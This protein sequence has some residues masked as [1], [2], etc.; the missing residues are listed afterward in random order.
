[1]RLLATTCALAL[2]AS[3]AQAEFTLTI[4]HTNDFHD[5]F[6]PI[7]AFA[8]TCTDEQRAA[9][10]CFGGIARLATALAEARARAGE[11]VI[12]LDA[13]DQFSGSLIFT[14]YGGAVAAE[15]MS[16]LG[17]DAMVPGNHEFNR[18]PQG[19]AEF[20]DGV[21]FPV[22]AA[23]LDASRE[24]L[25]AGR[26]AP[27]AV[28]E[29]AGARIGIVGVT[30]VETPVIS[31]PGPNLVF[32]P[33]A[34]VQHEIDRLTA[35]GVTKIVLLSHVGLAE[36]L[37][38]AAALTGVD[39]I[40]GGHSHSLL[41][42]LAEDAQGP[43]PI[44]VG[45]V[46][47]V[48]AGAFGKHLGELAVTFDAD[49]RVISAA[50]EPILLDAAVAEDA[51]T[52]AR[53]FELLGPLDELRNRVVA[54]AAAAIDGT[55]ELCRRAEC[56]MGNL[57]ADAILARAAG[58]GA[59]IALQN[60]GGL[61]ASIDS[62]P[63]TKGEVLTVLPFQNTLSTF[64]ATGQDLLDALENGVSQMEEG[65]GRFPQVAGLRFTVDPS[66]PVGARVSAVEVRQGDGWAPIDPAATYIVASNN[67]VRR[68]GD[69]YAMFADAAKAYDFGPDLAEVV[70][71]Y[72]AAN[73]PYAP[74]TD[75]R[76]TVLGVP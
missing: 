12:L 35:A 32:R 17:Y 16:A 54:E 58:Q 26:I 53:L 1:M 45:A 7:N 47:V 20:L 51:A 52:A 14:Q 74:Y 69:G 62:G 66:R 37:A 49:G 18:G 57:V 73:A 46:A 38:L 72:L 31:S 71:D 43:Y 19:L 42:N 63:I 11:N 44:M 36:D 76:I 8:S 60:G 21:D 4:L 33:H 6:E 64:E 25:L 39:V 75:G 23:N 40:V 48:Q 10:E 56:P 3:A 22:V 15:F 5:R 68:G 59:V 41:S 30:T 55:R 50:G 65:S 24:P 61:R 13:G 67:F 29:V 34:D 28:I 27:S 9:G 2:L 70:S